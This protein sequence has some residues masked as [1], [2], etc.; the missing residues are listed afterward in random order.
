MTAHR[1]YYSLI[2]FCPD[3]SRMEA[4]NVG[5]VLFCPELN[6]IEA[7]MAGDTRRAEQLTGRRQLERHALKHA[8]HAIERRFIYDRCAF[9][10]VGDFERFI[11]TRANSLRLTPQRPIKVTDP[12]S[13]LQGLYDTLVAVG[14]T[15]NEVKRDDPFP[16]LTSAFLDLEKEGK[17]RT[18]LKVKVPVAGRS[19]DIPFAYQNGKLNLIKPIVFPKR[20]NYSIDTALRL[21]SEGQLVEKYGTQ[22]NQEARLVIVSRFEEAASPEVESRIENILNE[23]NVK[24]VE[25]HE[26]SD[27]IDQVKLEAHAA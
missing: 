15:I 8:K 7:R 12:E 14:S 16:T 4:I 11:G 3:L 21:A 24:N 19:L 5:V 9:Q 2:Q 1:G 27:F 18:G 20:E 13:Q 6:F 26:I 22:D 23:F 25:E 10:E 17:A